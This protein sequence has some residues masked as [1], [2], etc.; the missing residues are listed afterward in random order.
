MAFFGMTP[1]GDF[2]CPHSLPAELAEHAAE[3]H[4]A[5]DKQYAGKPEA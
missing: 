5:E 3:G 2:P 1:S 4:W